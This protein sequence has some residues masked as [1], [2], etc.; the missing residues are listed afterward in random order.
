MRKRFEGSE[1]S[2]PGSAFVSEMAYLIG[3]VTLGERVSVLPFVCMRGDY[4]SIR[5][6]DDSNVQDFTMLHDDAYL[7]EAVTVGHGCVLDGATIGDET[8]VGMSS[9][10]LSGLTVGDNCIVAAG[11]LVLEDQTIPSGHLAYGAP[12]ETRPLDEDQRE[13]PPWN[14]QEY[15]DLRERY[16]T[17]GGFESPR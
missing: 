4:G 3:D 10:L 8:L 9:T 15:V 12:A 7:G 1:P 17:E 11:S 2:V 6:G 13:L 14:A 16:K 5:V